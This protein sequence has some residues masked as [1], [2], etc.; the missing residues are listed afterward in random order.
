MRVSDPR[1]MER[2]VMK[3]PRLKMSDSFFC[4]AMVKRGSS[5]AVAM[6]SRTYSVRRLANGVEMTEWMVKGPRKAA[7]LPAEKVAQ[8]GTPLG[9]G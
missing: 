9:V 7:P 4:C 1:R 2:K 5:G 6:R 3:R 8:M